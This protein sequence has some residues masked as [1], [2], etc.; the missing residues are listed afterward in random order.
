[1]KELRLRQQLAVIASDEDDETL[2]RAD[3][4]KIRESD[5][6]AELQT[7]RRQDSRSGRQDSRSGV[8]THARLGV[9]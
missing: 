2:T 9:A 4:E 1:M 5:A 3:A 7:L 6:R 8:K